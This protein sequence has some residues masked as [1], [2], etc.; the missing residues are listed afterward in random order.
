MGVWFWG[1]WVACPCAREILKKRS[2]EQKEKDCSI[3]LCMIWFQS[4]HKSC[5]QVRIFQFRFNMF[6]LA[7]E[8]PRPFLSHECPLDSVWSKDN[9]D[10]PGSLDSTPGTTKSLLNLTRFLSDGFVCT[11][12]SVG[13]DDMNTRFDS[14]WATLLPLE[15]W[16]L[17]W[18]PETTSSLVR[19]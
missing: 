19:K 7:L 13:P 18:S 14:V 10:S 1:I 17:G 2:K 12:R 4:S 11:L 15:T 9:M 5:E 16:I 8:A 6:L 3:L